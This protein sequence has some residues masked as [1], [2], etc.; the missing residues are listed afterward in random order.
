MAGLLTAAIAGGGLLGLASAAFAGTAPAWEP[1]ANAA[2]PYGNLTFYDAAGNQ[3]ISGTGDLDSPFAYAVAGTAADSGATKATLY[4]ANPNHGLPPGSWTVASEAGPTTFSPTIS[5]A[6]A[7]ITGF[8]PTDAVVASSAANITNWLAVNTPDTQ[9]GYANTIQVRLTD[10]GP[11]GHGTP[12]GNY[13]ESDIGYN[14]TSSPITVD[15]TTVPANGWA[16]LYPIV[17]NG[18]ITTLTA[19]ANGASEVVSNP[20]TLTASVTPTTASG[21]VN[22]YANGATLVATSTTPGSGTYTATWTPTVTGSYSITATFLPTAGG[23]GSIGDGVTITVGA[24][25]IGGTPT[26]TA[27]PT[28]GV[29]Y[30]VT[31]VTLTATVTYADYSKT[32]VAGT[33]KFMIGATLITGCT[34]PVATTVTGSGTSASPGLGTAVC[35]TSSLPV[36]SDQI[37]MTFSPPSGYTPLFAGP[38]TVTVAPPPNSCSYASATNLPPNGTAPYLTTPCAEQQNVQ[39]VINPGTITVTTPYTAASPFVLPAMTL[40]SDGTYFQSS[41]QFAS[42]SAGFITVTSSLAPAYAWT[43]SVAATPLV[44]GANQ[45]P[46][47]GLGLIGGTLYNASGSGAYPGTVTFV[48]GAA[49]I[50]SCNPSPTDNPSGCVTGGLGAA[51]QTW[52]TS[53]AADGTADMYGT[54]T[55]LAATST[56]TGTY[57]GIITFSVS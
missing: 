48:N 46:A 17:S 11:G 14:T 53:S 1:D 4:F 19:P 20:I 24:A 23:P 37:I 9:A 43:L 8:T 27:T 49:G 54:L 35:T 31:P 33:V 41:A 25:N 30:G 5:G 2:A 18:T 55:L 52:A 50:P 40:S 28:S 6:P 10:S 29:T 57:N 21:S 26:L 12:A 3:V 45:I 16:V 39:V 42:A 44:N 32:G 51:P 34:N 56:P 36:G 15:G 38:V 22:F 47:S 13:W 7:D